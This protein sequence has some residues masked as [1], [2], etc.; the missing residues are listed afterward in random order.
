M[1]PNHFQ[2]D[3]QSSPWFEWLVTIAVFL[4][5]ASLLLAL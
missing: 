5:L 4:A 3:R 1:A 2:R